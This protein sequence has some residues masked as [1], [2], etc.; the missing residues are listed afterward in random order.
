[1]AD[2]TD[3]LAL[4]GASVATSPH[5]HLLLHS[6]APINF[7]ATATGSVEYYVCHAC[8]AKWARTR[9]RSEPDAV[10]E[11]TTKELI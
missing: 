1:M 8:A 9:A 6:E 7:G 11:R 5:A 2:C 3:C 10:W 4:E